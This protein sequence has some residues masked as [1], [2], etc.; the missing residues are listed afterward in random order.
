MLL[1]AAHAMC[2]SP[3]GVEGGGGADP[4]HKGEREEGGFGQCRKS[5]GLRAKRQIQQQKKDF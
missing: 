4:E 1:N 5:T 2:G 3:P